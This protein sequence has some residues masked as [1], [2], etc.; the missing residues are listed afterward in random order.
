MLLTQIPSADALVHANTKEALNAIENSRAELQILIN[1]CIQTRDQIKTLIDIANRESTCI[2]KLSST[3]LKSEGVTKCLCTVDKC[4]GCEG[5]HEMRKSLSSKLTAANESTGNSTIIEF[6]EIIEKI[7]L[8][9]DLFE[10]FNELVQR[11]KSCK[12]DDFD[13]IRKE[14]G[15]MEVEMEKKR[16]GPEGPE[17]AERV[18][19]RI[20]A[21]KQQWDEQ[22]TFN[23]FI[24]YS[25]YD[26]MEWV[27]GHKIMLRHL[28]ETLTKT[29]TLKQRQWIATFE[30]K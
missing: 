23:K 28:L 13:E 7:N 16:G 14:I 24:Q 22:D 6:E 29:I 30:Q 19:L 20:D 17:A 27:H 21:L 9:I 2:A 1:F 3:L 8:L 18:R 5:D 26:E 25:V 12:H 11:G 10:S 15:S 4:E